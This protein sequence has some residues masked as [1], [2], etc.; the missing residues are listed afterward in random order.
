MEIEE[1][2]FIKASVGEGGDIHFELDG[3]SKAV[4]FLLCEMTNQIKQYLV[5]A[6]IDE[7]LAKRGLMKSLENALETFE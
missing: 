5:Q 2:K 6:G 3:Q 1:G 7:A 4:I